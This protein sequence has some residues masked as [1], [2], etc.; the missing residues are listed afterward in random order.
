MNTKF[1][2]YNQPEKPNIYLGTPNNKKICALTGIDEPTFK[3]TEKLSNTYELSFDISRTL[4]YTS[5]ITNETVEKENRAFRLISL[6]MRLYVDGYGWFIIDPPEED[7]DSYTD[8]YSITAQSAEIEFQQH[9]LHNFKVN[10]GTTDSY[11]MLVDG[12]VQMVGDVEFAKEQIKFYNA[13]NP[14]LSFLDICLKVAG[15]TG[16][17]VGYVDTVPKS[18]EYFDEGV[19]KEK[20]TLLADEIGVF[21]VDSKDLYSFLTQDAAKFFKCI[22]E[23][24]FDKMQ[25]NAYHPENYGKDTNVN[26]S[27]RNFQK[28]NNIK[29]DDTNIF[30]RYHV[31]GSNELGIEYVNFGHNYIEN[32]ENYLNE[33]YLSS[34]VIAKYKLWSQDV[35]NS[36]NDYI[37]NTRLYNKQ[38]AKISELTNKVPLDDCST[39]WSSFGDDKLKEAQENYQAQLK[40]YESYYVDENGDFDETA[41]KNSV[42]ADDYYQIKNVILPSIQIEMDNRNL[43]SGQKFEDYI[44]SYKTDW[45]LYGLDELEN[46][47]A[48]YRK[49]KKLAEDE[50]CTEP[51]NPENDKNSHTEDYHTEL[52]N[53]YIDAV[54]QLDPNYEG[55]C[56]EFYNKVKAEI[57]GL[58]ELQD[59]YDKARKEIAKSVAKETWVHAPND[60]VETSFTA[61][62][63]EELSHVYVDGDYSNENMFLTS[64]DDSVTAIDEQLK[65]LDAAQD[66][67]YITSHPQYQYTTNLDNFLG[68]YDF[69]E[70]SEKLNIG[71]YLYLSVR[72]DYVVKLRIISMEY[73]PLCYD[74][75]LQI[76]FSNMIQ[77]RSSRDD[78]AYI[79][80]QSGG[81][82]KNSSTGSTS[83]N[84]YLNNEGVSLTPA[85]I[86]KLVQS[87]AFQNQ[88]NN[89]INNNFGSY[90]GSNGG[91]I[92]ISELNAKMIK[93]V[94]IVGE[95]AF[96]EYLQSKF[97][98]TDTI[99]AGS[100]K[101]KDLQAL[102]AQIDNL[103]AGNISSEM[104]HIIK[105]T[106]EN[107]QID[108]A[109]IRDLIAANITVSM[110]KASEIDTDKFHVK[111][112]DGSLE[113]V[114]STMQFKDKNNVTRIQIGRD[115]ND[116]FTFCLYD[117]TGKGVLIDSSGIKE[118]A[119][120]DGLIK[121][122]M[123]A[124]GTISKEKL[125][126]NIVEADENGNIDAGK[127]LV[128]GKGIDVEFT[129]IKESINS[130]KGEIA[131]LEPSFN[132]A[133]GNESQN[134]PCTSKG[135]T[136]VPM[137]IEI[138]FVGYVGL[139]QI[140]CIA[141]VGLLPKGITLGEITNSTETTTGKII[142]NVAKDSDLGGENV[143][144]GTIQL[145]F[146]IAEKEVVKNF[147]WTKTK[148][149]EQGQ[150]GQNAR[151]FSLDTSTYVIKKNTDSTLTP[152][153]IVFSSY[154]KDGESDTRN[155]YLGRFLISESIDGLKYS[156]RYTSAK[157][158][159]T[160]TYTPSSSSI[161]SIKCI[162]CAS[163][164]ITNELDSQTVVVLTD[165]DGVNEKIKEITETISG[166]SS[167]VD[168][169]NK[170]ITDKVWQSDITNSIDNYDK[171]TIKIIRDQQAEQKTTVKGITT[172]VSDIKSQVEKKADGTTVQEL[173]EK[174][175]KNEQTA[176]GFRQ[177]V[178][179][180]Y[181]TNDKLGNYPTN[182]QME[183]A[184]SESAKEINL[185][186]SK[187]YATKDE[188][189]QVRSDLTVRANE[190]EGKVT[191]NE[192]NITEIIQ[193]NKQIQQSVT[194][195][196]NNIT[197]LQQDSSSF[198]QE[199]EKTYM[200]KDGLNSLKIGGRNLLRNSNT[201]EFEDYY[202]VDEAEVYLTDQDGNYIVD[203]QNNTII[204]M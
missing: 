46:K 94:D 171:T 156:T 138:P 98:S 131:D 35:E 13:S 182:T 23:F 63:L 86:Q 108:E 76:T 204:L 132:I 30:T 74:N 67:L 125:N 103:L 44:D 185:S 33:R 120:S 75:S 168:A 122:D 137:L 95:N 154:Y 177:E 176:E 102:V 60:G 144:N 195:A 136:S 40:G 162:L 130:I 64:S 8:K 178:V 133:V 58:K 160:V 169:V 164:G 118:S 2:K 62:D 199:V 78:I 88:L 43:P 172:T 73:N 32:L 200:T 128:N 107:V 180:N 38:Y 167:K 37:E 25:I 115:A 84:N 56:M 77:S 143:L 189:N 79:L 119:I 159:H 150:S 203:E 106:A 161:S 186:A 129:S 146:T 59:S 99:V 127:V 139:T 7:N 49:Q 158:E 5:P 34:E 113:I 1:N 123:V 26:I 147:T 92:S 87:G 140:P 47:L 41:L 135:L 194:D 157:D 55:S 196:N 16:W 97:I 91:S 175:S 114:G 65:L 52:Y 173:S 70:Y 170:S 50:K 201:L 4:N 193:T 153:T 61:S 18:Y 121:N 10:Q 184:I 145:T 85:L 54:H 51:Y 105:L 192:N 181:V 3:M 89:I 72:D 12:N 96:F 197:K 126:F 148:S 68:L 28:S 116:N 191:D 183:T 134:I 36:R 152:S 112:N 20:Q 17:T 80:N 11:E 111:S 69:K 110:L 90:L 188:N 29:I 45:K 48:W 142:L 93:V 21:D 22:F 166:V 81:S 101:F 163:E 117:E 19:R 71:D 42:D 100:G 15:V 124:D 39:D 6:F 104:A 198:K 66:D 53:K 165:A 24:D 179:K 82:S 149:G 14:E 151:L 109:V 83:S 174:V 57:D 190:I 27:F 187:T 141:S 31:Q 9:N 202:F 155:D